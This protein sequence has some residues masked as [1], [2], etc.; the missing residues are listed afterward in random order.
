MSNASMQ[1]QGQ[2]SLGL[3]LRVGPVRVMQLL[4]KGC[5]T[6]ILLDVGR[7]NTT[8]VAHC[9]VQQVQEDLEFSKNHALGTCF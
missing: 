8:V 2:D 3:W 6:I 7:N 9:V 5:F 4:V 1:P